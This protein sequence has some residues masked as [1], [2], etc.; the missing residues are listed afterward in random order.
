MEPKYD[1]FISYR[2]KD[3]FNRTTGTAYARNIQQTLESNGYKGRVFFDHNDMKPGDFEKIILSA[4]RS[5]KIFILVLTK[6]SMLRC[7]NE[8][9]WV[10][11][12]IL[13]AK[14][15]NLKILI[16]NMENEF[17]DSDYPENFPEELNDPVK[18]EH[19]L[20]IYTSDSYEREMKHIIDAYISPILPPSQEVLKPKEVEKNVKEVDV[21]KEVEKEVDHPL[22][23]IFK[24]LHRAFVPSDVYV[25]G[26]EEHQFKV[27]DYYEDFEKYGIIVSVTKDGRHGIIINLEEHE[28][29]WCSDEEAERTKGVSTRATSEYD[30]LHNTSQ[31]MNIVHWQT[32]YLA[33]KDVIIGSDNIIWYIPSINE[34]NLLTDKNTLDAVNSGLVSRGAKPIFVSGQMKKAF[35]SSTETSEKDF[36]CTLNFEKFNFLYK[37]EWNHREDNDFET[38]IGD[39]PKAECAYVRS[40][41]KF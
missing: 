19:H 16:I 33:F 2:R 14:K 28:T 11:R 12:E 39:R 38:Y 35:W 37:Q 3:R 8:E 29:Q 10:R 26:N 25:D 27:G 7:G 17:Q 31:V 30:G 21:T 1:I 20:V 34:L 22:K 13:E 6:D 4:I 41:A 36:V 24:I 5:A 32:N 9:D 15:C 18:K 40:F 23:R